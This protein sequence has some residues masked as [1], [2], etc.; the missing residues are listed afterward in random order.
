MLLWS[1]K[2]DLFDNC[3]FLK[4]LLLVF[5]SIATFLDQ[6]FFQFI[7]IFNY[8]DGSLF[9]NHRFV[10]IQF[11]HEI[12]ERT[13]FKGFLLKR[14]FNLKNKTW[15][16]LAL[17]TIEPCCIYGQIRYYCLIQNTYVKV[18]QCGLNEIEAEIAWKCITFS[19]GLN[20]LTLIQFWQIQIQT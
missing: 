2:I 11:T 3:I 9:I 8:I 20:F 4:N 12:S 16:F 18:L 1:R 17:S 14:F 5:Q 15:P 19:T 10:L 13:R 6:G 7:Q